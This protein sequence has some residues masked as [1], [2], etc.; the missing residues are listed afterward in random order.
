[1]LVFFTRTLFLAVVAFSAEVTLEFLHSFRKRKWELSQVCI[2]NSHFGL[3]K[4]RKRKFEI[5]VFP[6]SGKYSD[7]RNYEKQSPSES[8]ICSRVVNSREFMIIEFLVSP[9]QKE[10]M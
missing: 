10:P 1:V 5:S 2:W 3:V 6:P 7:F 8:M 9:S 4:Y